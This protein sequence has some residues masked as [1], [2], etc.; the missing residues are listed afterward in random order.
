MHRRGPCVRG[1]LDPA[2]AQGGGHHLAGVG[3]NAAAQCVG[4]VVDH[5]DAGAFVG[6]GQCS[7]QAKDPAAQDHHTPAVQHGAVQ[8][9]SILEVTQGDDSL[10]QSHRQFRVW[11]ESAQIGHHGAGAGG[12][13]EPVVIHRRS[14]GEVHQPA[15]AVHS[16]HAGAQVKPDAG[17]LQFRRVR[18]CDVIHGGPAHAK[19]GHQH[20]VVG[21]VWLVA[22][23]RECN[24]TGKDGGQQFI[25]KPGGNWPVAHHHNVRSPHPTTG[26]TRGWQGSARGGHGVPVPVIEVLKLPEPAKASPPPAWT[27]CPGSQPGATVTELV[28]NSGIPETGSV[29]EEVSRL[30]LCRPG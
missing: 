6:R 23:H 29:A 14:V 26:C 25:D 15:G 11:V 4:A 28:L 19:V 18:Q 13:N 24:G 5:R 17:R 27:G 9:G 7:L 2:G 1:H 16:A 30:A 21:R 8:C 10:G 3:V 20:A 12:E 22:D